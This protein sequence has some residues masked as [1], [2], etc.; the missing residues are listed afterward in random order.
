MLTE[1]R[2]IAEP[3]VARGRLP[4]CLTWSLGGGARAASRVQ[5]D[6]F[7][8]KVSGS[9]S[10]RRGLGRLAAGSLPTLHDYPST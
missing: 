10:V 5:F 4:V 8:K 6:K 2:G 7:L 9:P 1:E 3:A